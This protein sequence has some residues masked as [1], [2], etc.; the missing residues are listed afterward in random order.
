[1]NIPPVNDAPLAVS[2]AYTATAG[3]TLTIVAPGV[4]V[5]DSDIESDALNA[6]LNTDG[7]FVYLPDHKYISMWKT[8]LLLGMKQIEH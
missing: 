8:S 5:N 7:S 2:D 6:T 4:L 1:M 3:P